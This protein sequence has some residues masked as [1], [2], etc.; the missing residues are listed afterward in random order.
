MNRKCT[1]ND[2]G[3][4][5]KFCKGGEV[6]SPLPDLHHWPLALVLVILIRTLPLIWFPRPWT[7]SD[8]VIRTPAIETTISAA[9]LL[10]LLNIWPWARLWWLLRRYGRSIPSLMLRQPEHQSAKWSIPLWHSRRC[11]LNKSIPRWL[12]THRSSGNSS[13]PF[14]TMCHDTIFLGQGHVNQLTKVIGLHKVQAFFE[15]SA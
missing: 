9:S 14:S 10:D 1:R 15:L 2:G 5:R 3:S 8:E 12:N 6:N 4:I 7:I 11:I 13:F